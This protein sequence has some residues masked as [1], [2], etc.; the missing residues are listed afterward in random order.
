MR[1]MPTAS[2]HVSQN[3]VIE[4]MKEWC[5]CRELYGYVTAAQG[6]TGTGKSGPSELKTLMLNVNVFEGIF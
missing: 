2:Q 3:I 1:S 6:G 5:V 4:A